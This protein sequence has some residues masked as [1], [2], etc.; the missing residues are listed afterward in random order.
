VLPDLVNED[1]TLPAETK[2]EPC[3]SFFDFRSSKK[4]S[5]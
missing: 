1:S 5:D 2:K 4:L 3:S